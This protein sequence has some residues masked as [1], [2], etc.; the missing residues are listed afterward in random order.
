MIPTEKYKFL[1][2]GTTYD[3]HCEDFACL[4]KLNDF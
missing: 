2:S 3:E 1:Y 4:D